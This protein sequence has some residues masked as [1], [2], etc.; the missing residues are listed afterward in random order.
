MTIYCKYSP[1]QILGGVS[2]DLHSMYLSPQKAQKK[3][4]ECSIYSI[5]LFLLQKPRNNSLITKLVNTE[6]LIFVAIKMIIRI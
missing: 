6:S 3:P 2:I 5:T 4:N 1:L